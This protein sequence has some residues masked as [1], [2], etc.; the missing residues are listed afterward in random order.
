[1]NKKK[2]YFFAAGVFIALLVVLGLVWKQ[3]APVPV[4]GEKHITVEVIHKDGSSREFTYHTDTEYLG[5]VL[6]EAGLISGTEGEFGLYV[7][8]VDGETADFSVDQ[9][10]WC[11]MHNGETAQTGADT[12]PI[13]DGDTFAWVYT[14]G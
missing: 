8:T 5:P 2:L 6:E 4:V 7:N 10:W 13:Q 11:L 1:M 14:I 3:N 9:G 12:L